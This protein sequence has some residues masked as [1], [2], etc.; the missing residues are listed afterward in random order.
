MAAIQT[1]LHSSRGF[2]R[3]SHETSSTFVDNTSLPVHR[4][5]RFPAGFSAPWAHDVIVKLGG[6]SARVLDPFVGCGTTLIE[7]ERAGAMTVG[8]EAHPF[9]ARVAQAKLLWRVPPKDFVSYAHDISARAM[10][11]QGN[12]EN[13]PSLVLR[14]YSKESLSKLDTLRAEWAEKADGSPFSELVWLA[15]VG[16]LR[17][18][19]NVGTAPWQYI[20]PRKTKV[21]PTSPFLAF[22]N[23]VQLM[24]TDMA[25]RQHENHGPKA[26]VVRDDIRTTYTVEDDWATLVVTSPPYANNYDYADATRLELSFF[27]EVRNWGDLQQKIRQYL[28]R[29]CT[30]HVAYLGDSL[31]TILKGARVSSIKEELIEVCGKLRSEQ[32]KHKGKKP[33]DRMIAGYFSDLSEVWMKLRRITASDAVVCFVVGDSAPYGIYVPVD[34]WLGELAVAAGFESYS[35]EKLRDRNVKWRNRKHRIPLHEGRLWVYG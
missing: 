10:R 24:A 15:I 29:A 4:W 16:I 13:Y 33:Y 1:R 12:T 18:S 14:C 25:T 22:E 31:E 23:Q 9:L 20:L 19:S 6:P 32:P 28:V 35:F 2:A 27:G 3:F 5:F 34:R 30:Q 11:R 7:G 17:L 21:R 8:V 26:T